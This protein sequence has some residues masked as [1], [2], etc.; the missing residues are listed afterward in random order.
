MRLIVRCAIRNIIRQG[1][2]NAP[3]ALQHVQTDGARFQ[4]E[5]MMRSAPASISSIT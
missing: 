3:L 5:A 1:G 4:A 2:E